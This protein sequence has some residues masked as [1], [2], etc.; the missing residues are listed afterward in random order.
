MNWLQ[1]TLRVKRSIILVILPW[2]LF[3]GIYGFLVSLLNYFGLSLFPNKSG[4]ITD[5]VLSF[6]IGLT[7]LLVFR[8]NTAH[9]RFWEGRKLWGSLVNTVRNLARDI[10]I[11]V[12]ERSPQARLEKEATLRLVV[13]FAVAM[14]LHL[15]AEPVNDELAPLMSSFQYFK[16]KELNH[17]PLEIAFWIGDYLQYQHDQ[18]CLNIYQLAALHKLVDDLVDILGG[19]ERILKTPVPLIYSIILKQLVV[20]YCLILPF[21]LV[22]DLTWWTGPVTALVSFTLLSIEEV[23]AEIEEP[24]GHDPNDLPLDGICQTMLRNVEELIAIAPS[25]TRSCRR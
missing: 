23:G 25:S 3:F 19:C 13:A 20:V 14:K 17:P 5:A 22:R 18:N 1:I 7:L 15:R 21:E 24:F 12:K 10:W 4:V 16:L 6:N 8:T 11:V 9:E 2:V